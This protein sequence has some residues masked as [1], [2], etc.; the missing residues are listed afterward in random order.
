MSILN[1]PLQ[2]ALGAS[3]VANAGLAVYASHEHH[4]ASDEAAGRKADKIS[5][6]NAQTKAAANALVQKAQKEK[7]DAERASKADA[8]NIA[9]RDKYNAAILRHQAAQRAASHAHMSE[10]P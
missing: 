2:I 8:S 7:I 3:L 1:Y 6:D 4:R 10:I 9:L 5:Y